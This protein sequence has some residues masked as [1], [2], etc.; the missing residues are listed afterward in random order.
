MTGP[1]GPPGDGFPGAKV[2]DLHVSET[3]IDTRL[4]ELTLKDK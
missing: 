3:F 1:R 2:T 4:T